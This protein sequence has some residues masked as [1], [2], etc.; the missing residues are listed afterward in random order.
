MSETVRTIAAIVNPTSGN[1]STGREWPNILQ[2]L[3]ERLGSITAVATEW[4][5]HGIALSRSLL[6]QGFDLVIAV[7]GDGTFNEVVNGF[8]ENDRPVRP[9]ARL[10]IITSGTGSDFRR[11]LGS[12]RE[13]PRAIEVLATGEPRTVDVGTIAYVDFRGETRHRYFA[14]MVSFGL[15]GAVADQANR[16]SKAL[17]GTLS[18]LRA[19]TVALLR[20]RRKRVLLGMDGEG[21]VSM[22]ITNVAVGNGRYHGGGMKACPGALLDDGY[23]DVT[24]FDDVNALEV[25]LGMPLLYA[26]KAHWHPKVRRHRVRQLTARSEE[27]VLIEVDGEQLGRLPIEISVS[28]RCLPVIAPKAR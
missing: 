19:T 1:G 10:G 6:Q 23:L 21:A 25:L 26:G 22:R 20:F 12:P 27:E 15:G 9:G 11:T 18:F 14:N 5:G 28:P 8:F 24:I 4:P 7:G 3:K 2:G 16:T 17:G 13:Y